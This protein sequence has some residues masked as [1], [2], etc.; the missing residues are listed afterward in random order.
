MSDLQIDTMIPVRLV[1]IN[2][3]ARL[4]SSTSALGHVTYVVHFTA[5][6]RHYYG[7]FIVFRDYY[8]LYGLPMFYYIETEKELPGH[9]ILFRSDENG[10]TIEIAKG[11]KPG[12]I[13]L[14]IVNVHLDSPLIKKMI[15]QLS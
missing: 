4:A 5:N 7:I 11:T 13:T 2:D 12:Y 8:K 9:Y 3:L 1:S 6:S 15:P 14:P 10:E